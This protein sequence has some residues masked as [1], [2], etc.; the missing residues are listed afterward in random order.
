MLCFCSKHFTPQQRSALLNHEVTGKWARK[1]C[2]VLE[3]SGT[4]LVMSG[5]SRCCQPAGSSS[6]ACHLSS[7]SPVP[8]THT[9]VSP[10][11]SRVEAGLWTSMISPAFPPCSESSVSTLLENVVKTPTVID[12]SSSN[13]KQMLSGEGFYI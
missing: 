3:A 9:G 4:T 13:A 11:H 8:S 1:P 2:A 6:R 7:W 10:V 12:L 5:C